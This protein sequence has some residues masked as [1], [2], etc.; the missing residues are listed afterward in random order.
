MSEIENALPSYMYR[1]PSESVDEIRRQR[2][3][4]KRKAANARKHKSRRIQSL[5]KE[6][7][8]NGGG[9]HGK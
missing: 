9:H 4:E 5:V 1:D 7:I 3:I 2:E 6:V 8:R